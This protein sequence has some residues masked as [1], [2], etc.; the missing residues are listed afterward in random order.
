MF[1]DKTVAIVGD[2]EIPVCTKDVY[3][4]DIVICM[5]NNKHN[6]EPDVYC[7]SAIQFIDKY[8][9]VIRW[10]MSPKNRDK[11]PEGVKFYEEHRWHILYN[12]L[13]GSRPTTGMMTIDMVREGKAKK[14]T[15]FGFDFYD[16]GKCSAVHS[17]NDERRLCQEWGIL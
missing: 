17:P 13:M 11:A 6:I 9:D 8:P 5:N 12:T 10:H 15:L 2:A 16:T 7:Y 14:I 1:K 4:H 3:A